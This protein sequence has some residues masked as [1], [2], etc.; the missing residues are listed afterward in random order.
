MADLAPFAHPTTMPP[1]HEVQCHHHTTQPLPHDPTMHIV[2]PWPQHAT[3]AL[4]R[5]C[6]AHSAHG[7]RG[8][9]PIVRQF[10]KIG[11]RTAS[12]I[13]V[14]R[15]IYHRIRH[16]NSVINLSHLCHIFCNFSSLL[17]H[18]FRW[19]S[20]FSDKDL[21]SPKIGF[22]LQKFLV[23]KGHLSSN[24]TCPPTFLFFFYHGDWCSSIIHYLCEKKL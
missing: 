4:G 2:P 24:I 9:P 10:F 15:L 5:P 13:S 20:N 12:K 16:Q 19:P 14:S 3:Q 22:L 23:T 6:V 1:P 21:L 17:C 7:T 18:E 8:T 11:Y